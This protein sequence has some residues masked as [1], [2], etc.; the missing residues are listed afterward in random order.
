MTR[1]TAGERV[2]GVEAK[3]ADAAATTITVTGSGGSIPDRAFAA[4]ERL[5]EIGRE[6]DARRQR[7]RGSG[8]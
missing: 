3:R 2:R 6:V 1:R 4:L 8:S 5:I 7:E